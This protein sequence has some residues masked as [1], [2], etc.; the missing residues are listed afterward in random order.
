MVRDC[1]LENEFENVT[2]KLIGTREKDGRVYNLPTSSEIV[3]LIIGDFDGAFD[4]RDIIVRSKSGALQRIN[5]LHPSYL[6]MQYPL[7]FPY[8]E[9]GYRLGIL[10]NGVLEDDDSLRVRLTMR[11]FF[12]L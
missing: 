7:I 8:A 4:N 2:L 6:A 3:A 1:V 9:D 11:E 5:E 10:H 12:F